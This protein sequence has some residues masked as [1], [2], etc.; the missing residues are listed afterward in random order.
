[1]LVEIDLEKDLQVAEARIK[2][3]ESVISALTI[4][5][6]YGYVD[7]EGFVIGFEEIT[8]TACRVLLERDI[9]NQVK[10]VVDFTA[11]TGFWNQSNCLMRKYSRDYQD[12]IKQKLEIK[13]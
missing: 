3:L 4:A 8:E 1:M 12:F 9:M 5:D 7:G 6:E 11:T 10:G 13:K 2:K